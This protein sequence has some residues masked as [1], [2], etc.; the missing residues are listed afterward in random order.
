MARVSQRRVQPEVENKIYQLLVECVASCRNQNAA[1]NFIDVLLTK[2]EK[3]MIGKRIAI[4]LM[5]IKGNTPSEIDEKLKVSQTTAYTVKTWLDEK[6][7]EYRQLLKEIA[8]RDESQQSR[9]QD[10]REEAE[11]GF[12]PPRPGT[13]WKELKRNQ[14]QKAKSAK[15][16]F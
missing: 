1:G 15:V 11:G 14:W 6:G 5:L 12:L 4:A 3:L 2:T 9:Y 8:D 13:N 16:P 10:L 7:K